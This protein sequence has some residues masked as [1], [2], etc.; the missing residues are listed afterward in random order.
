MLIR[1]SIAIILLCGLA[2]ASDVLISAAGSVEKHEGYEPWNMTHAHI[3][4][5]SI[6]VSYYIHDVSLGIELLKLVGS[7][8]S[9]DI[10]SGAEEILST[11]LGGGAHFVFEDT[12]YCYFS[13]QDGLRVGIHKYYD[14]TF[15]DTSIVTATTKGFRAFGLGYDEANETW[16]AVCKMGGGGA[17]DSIGAFTTSGRITAASTW[18]FQDAITT[19]QPMQF[20]AHFT[21]IHKGVLM[22]ENQSNEMHF[23]D[24]SGAFHENTESGGSGSAIANV[25]R[26]TNAIA[27]GQRY[28][29]ISMVPEDKEGQGDTCYIAYTEDDSAMVVM[30]RTWLDTSD[31]S[32]N[33]LETDTLYAGG[34]PD[35]G[36]ADHLADS[37]A[38]RNPGIQ[39]VGSQGMVI[40]SKNGS[41]YDESATE[42]I[43][44]QYT[45]YTDRR[46]FSTQGNFV[47][48]SEQGSGDDGKFDVQTPW[49]Y[50]AHANTDSAIINTTWLQTDGGANLYWTPDTIAIPGA[51]AAPPKSQIMRLNLIE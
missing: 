44:I 43:K 15:I 3:V 19:A 25:L 16:V 8:A 45:I 28:Y 21:P 48:M 6:L 11:P 46:D 36:Q 30:L 13:D 39:M 40:W 51:A 47:T 32:W 1:I 27:S 4:Q 42:A 31:Y 50:M 17:N 2:A 35:T 33:I 20:M 24:S 49:T 12:S 34:I 26:V 18:A 5:D 23:I 14:N 10:T 29:D 22:W 38:Y 37:M 41:D 9:V 7:S